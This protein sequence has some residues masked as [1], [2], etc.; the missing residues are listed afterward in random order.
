MSAL[1]TKMLG[2]LLLDTTVREMMQISEGYKIFQV[3]VLFCSFRGLLVAL[4]S[5]D[6]AIQDPSIAHGNHLPCVS[7]IAYP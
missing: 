3:D 2:R 6:C 4:T 5:R 1:Q 7:S